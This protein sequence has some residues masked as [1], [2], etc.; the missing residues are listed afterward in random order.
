MGH[1]KHRNFEP[2]PPK[3]ENHFRGA[4]C[5]IVAI[6]MG[7]HFQNQGGS[8][9]ED[10]PTKRPQPASRHWGWGLAM[11]GQNFLSVVGGGSDCYAC[12][13]RA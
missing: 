9:T 12:M 5:N 6:Q 8:R 2:L 3:T 10:T 11:Q 13:F 1:T 4:P 7:T